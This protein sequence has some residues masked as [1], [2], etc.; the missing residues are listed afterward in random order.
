MNFSEAITGL[1]KGEKLR[2]ESWPEEVYITF[3]ASTNLISLVIVLDAN[4]TTIK[5]FSVTDRVF[6]FEDT[7]AEDWETFQDK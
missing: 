7:V 4:F 2:R 1:L 5:K 6:T 3:T